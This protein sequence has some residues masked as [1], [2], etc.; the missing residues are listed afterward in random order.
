MQA[1]KAAELAER[2]GAGEY[3]PQIMREA[4]KALAQAR[5]FALASSRRKEAV[6]FSRRSVTLFGEAIQI[7]RRRKQR[8]ALE[9]EIEKRQQEM[10]ALEER[11]RQAELQAQ[12]AARQAE[13]AKAAQAEAEEQKRIASEAVAATQAEL[14]KLEQEKAALALEKQGLVDERERLLAE[15]QGLEAEKQSL[16][17]QQAELQGSVQ[18]LS[19]RAERLRQEREQLSNRLQGALSQVAETR[20]SARGYIVNLP[21]ILFDLNEASLKHQAQVVIA[22]LSGILLIMPELNLRIEGHTDSTGSEEYNQQLS[23]ERADSVRRFL[24]AQGVSFDRMVSEGYG[25]LRPVADNSTKD[26]RQRNRRVEIVISEGTIA[27]AEPAS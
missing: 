3:A 9:R 5:N 26:G 13:A 25:E 8:E 17:A 18:E 14:A 21:D 7:T 24:H 12:A 16:V 19:D 2:E 1:D 11:A 4:T 10:A 6:D 20:D 22:K 27:E 15:K 23:E